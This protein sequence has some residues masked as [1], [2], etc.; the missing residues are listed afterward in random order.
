MNA[1]LVF[2][3]LEEYKALSNYVHVNSLSIRSRVQEDDSGIH[4]GK[5]YAS[6]R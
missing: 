3:L 4:V 2:L 6:A 1:A 5:K